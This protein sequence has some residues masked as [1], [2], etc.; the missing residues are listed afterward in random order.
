MVHSARTVTRHV[1]IV[2]ILQVATFSTERVPVVA[3]LVCK[4]E[5]V[6]K[7][8]HLVLFIIKLLFALLK[9]FVIF[10]KVFGQIRSDC[11][12]KKGH[13]LNDV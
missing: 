2:S 10:G 8:T 12:P 9:H 7:V 1:A 6:Y 5:S 11:K 13:I 3:R 4:D